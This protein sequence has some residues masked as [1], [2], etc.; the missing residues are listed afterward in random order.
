MEDFDAILAQLRNLHVFNKADNLAQC[1]VNVRSVGPDLT[2]SEDGA[3]PEVVGIT[4]RDR[5]VERVRHPRFDL[6]DD[7]AFTLERMVLGKEQRQLEDSN[8]HGSAS[9]IAS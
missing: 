4:L 8:D 1:P 9:R 7:T 3:L 2:D 5:N 6:L